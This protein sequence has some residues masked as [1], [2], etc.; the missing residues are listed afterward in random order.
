MRT[1]TRQGSHRRLAQTRG[2]YEEGRG[3]ESSCDAN[4]VALSYESPK[5]VVK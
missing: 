3:A 5:Y 4:A 2:R 1:I